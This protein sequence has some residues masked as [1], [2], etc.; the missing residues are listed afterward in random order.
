MRLAGQLQIQRA[1]SGDLGATAG[2]LLAAGVR[3]KFCLL[4]FG[5][6]FPQKPVKCRK[7]KLNLTEKS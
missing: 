7:V 1:K 5:D 4:T 2:P 6:R 3:R